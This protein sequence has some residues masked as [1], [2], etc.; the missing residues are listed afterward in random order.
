M[1]MFKKGKPDPKDAPMEAHAAASAAAAAH[2]PAERSPHR[3][4]VPV[5]AKAHEGPA[6]SAAAA[7][8]A[9]PVAGA[10]ATTLPT[11]GESLLEGVET[12]KVAETPVAAIDDAAT[13][14]L[15]HIFTEDQEGLRANA[16]I[17]DAFMEQLTMEQVAANAQ[18]LLDDLRAAKK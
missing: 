13:S 14:N 18:Q 15:M 8:A 7:P 1:P 12:E 10:P 5:A 11:P 16:T 4:A 2:A 17:Y 9:G 6:A 3:D